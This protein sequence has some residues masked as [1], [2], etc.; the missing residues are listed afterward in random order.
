MVTDLLKIKDYINKWGVNVTDANK[1]VYNNIYC[2]DSMRTSLPDYIA[3]R[4]AVVPIK[5]MALM[6][7]FYMT[8]TKQSVQ[9]ALPQ[10]KFE[11]PDSRILMAGHA[12]LILAGTIPFSIPIPVF[13]RSKVQSQKKLRKKLKNILRMG[14]Q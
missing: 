2:A 5:D 4:L 11:G 14:I 3:S 9:E 7:T 6:I 1:V 12:V 13:G 10:V 8:M